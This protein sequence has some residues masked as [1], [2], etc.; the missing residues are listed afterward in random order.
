MENEMCDR[1]MPPHIAHDFEAMK[2][3]IEEKLYVRSV[4]LKG[5]LT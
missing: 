1:N 5:N 2:K 4:V 3:G